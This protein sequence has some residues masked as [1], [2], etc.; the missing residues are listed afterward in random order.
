[1]STKPP[2]PR[3]PP[4]PSDTG[5]P[6]WQR[7]DVDDDLFPDELPLEPDDAFEEALEQA[8]ARDGLGQPRRPRLDGTSLPPMRPDR[9]DDDLDDPFHRFS[10]SRA[11]TDIEKLA[12]QSEEHAGGATGLSDAAADGDPLPSPRR[13]RW[14][15]WTATLLLGTA[16]VVALVALLGVWRV[17][18]RMDRLESRI[19]SA[20]PPSNGAT[21]AP[22]NS[23]AQISPISLNG[24]REELRA[25]TE[26]VRTQLTHE[27]LRLQGDLRELTMRSEQRWQALEAGRVEAARNVARAPTPAASLATPSSAPPTPHSSTPKPTAPQAS[28]LMPAKPAA[29]P[30]TLALASLTDPALATQEVSRLRGLGVAAESQKVQAAGKTWHRISVGGFPTREA[31]EAYASK[32][33]GNPKLASSFAHYRI[34]GR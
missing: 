7:D 17:S 23:A 9:D 11:A 31:A 16:G 8:L 4:K 1:M 19:A 32:A 24:L 20:V 21:K 2:S 5:D 26:Q 12:R 6:R 15:S 13:S 34:A 10:A 29:G 18:A 27:T 28:K 22:A 3:L 25:L 30:W 33:K 14:R